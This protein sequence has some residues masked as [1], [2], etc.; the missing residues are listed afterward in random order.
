MLQYLRVTA[1][2]DVYVYI[3][4]ATGTVQVLLIHE[5]SLLERDGWLSRGMGG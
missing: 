3:F 2:C 4:L 5:S 1:I